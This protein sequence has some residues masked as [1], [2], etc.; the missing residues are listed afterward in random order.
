MDKGFNHRPS[1][2]TS[3]SILL[4]MILIGNSKALMP[5]QQPPASHGDDEK[6]LQSLNVHFRGLS[7]MW[8]I[9]GDWCGYSQKESSLNNKYTATSRIGTLGASDFLKFQY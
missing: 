5:Q 9:Q 8:D 6:P 4:P 1:S 3:S 7:G 2:T